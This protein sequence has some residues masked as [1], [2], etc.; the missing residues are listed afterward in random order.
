MDNRNQLS[1]LPGTRIEASLL[2]RNLSG[3]VDAAFIVVLAA[4]IF[5]NVQ[6]DIIQN[7][8]FRLQNELLVLLMLALYRF[9]M[10][11]LTSSTLGMAFSGIQLL[12]ADEEKLSLS[13]KLM[14][15]FFILFRG[16]DY[17]RRELPW[18]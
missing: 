8:R 14:A 18:R 6:L 5:S 12:T 1:D 13:Q 3:L 7:P 16:V 2:R 17:Y 11:A 10:L 15:A 4:L 9:L